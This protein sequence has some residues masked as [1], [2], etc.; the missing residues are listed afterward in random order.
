MNP[1]K[2]S[3]FEQVLL[4]S[5]VGKGVSPLLRRAD[6]EKEGHHFLRYLSYNCERVLNFYK[7]RFDGAFPSKF[8]LTISP[9]DF[10]RLGLTEK[11]IEGLFFDRKLVVHKSSGG[12]SYARA[13]GEE[14]MA[15][16]FC[17]PIANFLP[18]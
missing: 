16:F 5:S 14:K 2:N 18:N 13:F 7:V 12:D 3:A 9:E 15:L 10:E 4:H 6:F 1:T 17:A 11:K 8:D